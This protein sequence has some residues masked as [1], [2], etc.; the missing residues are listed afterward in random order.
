MANDFDLEIKWKSGSQIE[1]QSGDAASL[2][3]TEKV[4]TIKNGSPKETTTQD[5]ANLGGGGGTSY[6]VWDAAY[7][8]SA[9]SS[10]VGA[11]LY[12]DASNNIWQ[13]YEPTQNN[14]VSRSQYAYADSIDK[15]PFDRVS[16]FNNRINDCKF[17]GIASDAVIKNCILSTMVIDLSSKTGFSLNQVRWTGNYGDGLTPNGKDLYVTGDRVD[18]SFC[19]LGVQT[20]MDSI[21]DDNTIDD[22]FSGVNVQIKFN[23]HTDCF[24]EGCTLRDGAK[25]NILADAVEMYEGT[26]GYKSVLNAHGGV[27]DTFFLSGKNTISLTNDI[28]NLHCELNANA[29]SDNATLADVSLGVGSIIAPVAPVSQKNYINVGGTTYEIGESSGAATLTPA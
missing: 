10:P 6:L 5:I 25:V 7:Q 17:S 13:V 18:I 2:D 15:I 22:I 20:F 8:N 1:I 23:N 11:Y 9:M 24:F 3:G 28:S 16:W 29:S 21:G 19:V 26:M 14:V 27:I 12:K 4:L